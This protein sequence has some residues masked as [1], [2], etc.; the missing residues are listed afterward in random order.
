MRSDI[1]ALLN[2]LR[3]SFYDKKNPFYVENAK[4]LYKVAKENG[5]SGT[6]YKAIEQKLVD[7]YILNRFRRDFYK[8]IADDEKK[9]N[10]I[11]KITDILNERKIDHIYLK[12]SHLKH[13]YPETYMRSMG[14]I[15][16]LVKEQDINKTEDLLIKNGF[17][18]NSKGP[19]HDILFYGEIEVEVHRRLVFE[20]RDE[21]F[22][23]LREA[24]DHAISIDQHVYQLE[25]EYELIYLL[26]HNKKHLL[27]GG[28]GLRNV[29]DIG[30]FLEQTIDSIDCSKLKALL[31]D[32]ETTVFF[33]KM[34]IFNDR[35]LGLNLKE[36]FNIEHDPDQLLYQAFT[37]YVV[38][39]GVHGYGTS[40][41]QLSLRFS[42]N[43]N[44]N[45][46]KFRTILQII[47]PSY[48]SLRYQYPKMLKHKIWLPVAWLRRMFKVLFKKT[49]RILLYFKL[50][51]KSKSKEIMKVSKIYKKIGI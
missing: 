2:A 44:K 42:V 49:K 19:V 20:E 8:F 22:E 21:H 36:H 28:I 51:K 50:F 33:Q 26:Y 7:M 48:Q 35:Y 46:S 40:H 10:L 30:V 14:D 5:F 32:T 37:D 3:S 38:D 17:D 41:N 13:L 23:V 29:I 4:K 45:V 16:I 31:E 11:T 34:I 39:S 47:F 15:D 24:W 25:P 18:L 43:K 9:L 1:E 12:G 6:I 27:N